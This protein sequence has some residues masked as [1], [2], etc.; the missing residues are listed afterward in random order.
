M[1][2]A[3]I[4]KK[5]LHCKFTQFSQSEQFDS[6]FTNSLKCGS[7]VRCLHFGPHIEFDFGFHYCG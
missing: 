7:N 1:T 5:R 2:N 4:S 6:A 3:V